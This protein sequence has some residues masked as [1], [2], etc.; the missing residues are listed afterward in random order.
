MRRYLAALRAAGVRLPCELA[1]VTAVPLTIRHRWVDGPTLLEVTSI[2]PA[3]FAGAVRTVGRWIQNLAGADARIDANLANFC[4]RSGE[5]VLVDVLP[6]LIPSLRPEP[7]DLFDRLFRAL[8]FDT[9]ITL[10]ALAGYSLRATLGVPG[11]AAH[12]ARLLPVARELVTAGAPGPFPAGWFRARAVL[13]IRA[14]EGA[15]HPNIVREFFELTSVLAFRQL[16]ET[17]RRQ[18]IAKVRGRI[19]ELL[20]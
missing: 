2:S 14:A 18:R 12:T 9:A 8:C 15:D 1:I 11:S 7:G 3:A 10:D 13:A 16:G 6:P 19:R 4:M 5:P 20:R 17:S